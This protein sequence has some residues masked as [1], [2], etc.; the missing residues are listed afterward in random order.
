VE[1][2]PFF[3]SRFPGASPTPRPVPRRRVCSTLTWPRINPSAPLAAGS[4]SQIRG[5][6]GLAG[7][8][9]WNISSEVDLAGP[10][11]CDLRWQ[12]MLLPWR[13][14]PVGW[15]ELGAP[16]AGFHDASLRLPF[17]NQPIDQIQLRA[18]LSEDAHHVTLS[19]A[20]AFG[21]HWT[22]SLDRRP[23]DAPWQFAL[24][25]DRLAAADLDRWI[26]PRWRESFLGRMLPFLNPRPSANTVP[27]NLQATGRLTLARFALAPLEIRRLQGN[28]SIAGSHVTLTDATGQFYGGALAGSLDAQLHA[29]PSYDMRLE[30][31]AV[32]L[33][34][35]SSNWPGLADLFAG[36]A[37]GAASLQ[38][39]GATREDLIS[40][41]ACGG[42]VRVNAPQLR[43]I[44]LAKSLREAARRPGVSVFHEAS[45]AF[46]CAAGKLRFQN[47]LLSGPEE[48]IGASGT[49]DFRRNLDLRLQL[50]PRDAAP[51]SATA[52]TPIYQLTGSLP[53]LQIKRLTPPE[54]P[55]RSR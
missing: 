48:S 50:L 9:G 11:S 40:S 44:D 36:S 52:A 1:S 51:T 34:A 43:N 3:P 15:M 25:A 33:S 23:L 26:N 28:L 17:L 14:R 4:A 6:I 20:Q 5:V 54:P 29:A 31:S 18:D 19:S 55:R 41:L 2:F 53:T 10:F 46:S 27:E 24:S 30:F 8:L 38:T 35:L 21:A 39:Q 49:I 47:L 13:A 12:G 42:T 32:D 37:S 45:T 22:G 7:A 16:P